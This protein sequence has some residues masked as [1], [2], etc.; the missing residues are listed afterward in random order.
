MLQDMLK[1][2]FYF[3]QKVGDIYKVSAGCLKAWCCP[4][5]TDCFRVPFPE[6]ATPEDKVLLLAAIIFIDFKYFEIN[7]D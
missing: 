6:G 7:K 3:I 2:Y 1:I 5:S 4:D